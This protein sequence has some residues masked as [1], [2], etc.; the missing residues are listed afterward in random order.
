MGAGQPG[1]QHFTQAS[2]PVPHRQMVFGASCP[3]ELI[4]APGKLGPQCEAWS[5][6]SQGR[7]ERSPEGGAKARLPIGSQ[8]PVTH[9]P[10]EAIGRGGSRARGGETL[11]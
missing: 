7:G 8:E 2:S 11:P 6:S 4:G 5:S 9:D 1:F 10:W 3:T